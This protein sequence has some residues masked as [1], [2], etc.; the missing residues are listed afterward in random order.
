M[1]LMKIKNDPVSLPANLKSLPAQGAS[2]PLIRVISYQIDI[3]GLHLLLKPLFKFLLSGVQLSANYFYLD[4]E[5]L[6]ATDD[7]R[8]H[9]GFKKRGDSWVM[10]LKPLLA[11]CPDTERIV[12]TGHSLGKVK[13][14]KFW[15]KL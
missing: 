8:V 15:A 3:F 13:H 14:T 9:R 2:F 12:V 10:T 4:G 6:C 1:F 5:P 11:S 7:L